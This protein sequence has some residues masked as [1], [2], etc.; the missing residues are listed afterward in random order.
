MT[1]GTYVDTYRQNAVQTASP[2]QLVIMLY[3]GAI[4]FL[5]LAKTAM[6]EKD[7]YAQNQNIQKTQK[8][9]TELTSCLDMKQGGVVAENL[10][11]LYTYCY[12]QLTEANLLDQKE[13]IETC[14]QLLTELRES[15]TEIEIRNRTSQPAGEVRLAS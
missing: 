14:I 15:W 3:D 11:A 10:F 12:N 9:L 4:R 2:L 7:L 1:R 8:I 13:P 5:Q 6:E